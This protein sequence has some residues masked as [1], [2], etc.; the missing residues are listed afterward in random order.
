MKEMG[1]QFVLGETIVGAMERAAKMEAKGYTY[2]YDMLGEAARTEGDAKRYHLAYSRAI[3][4]IAQACTHA[5]I[6][7]N[8]G[9]SVKLSAL[10]PRYE[11]AQRSRVMDEL[12]PRLRSLALLA[13]SAGMGL[14]VDAEEADRLAISMDVIEEVLSEPALAGWDGFGVVVQAYGQRAGDAIDYL[15]ALA[16]AA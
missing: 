15:N 8:P 4:A 10:H 13:K 16:A 3:T 7:E 1:R 9:I 14:N 11:E 12:A 6:R 5:E 2:S